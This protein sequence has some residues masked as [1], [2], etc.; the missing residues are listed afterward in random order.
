[1]IGYVTLGTNDIERGR[2]FYDGLLALLGAKRV[3]EFPEEMGGFTLWG[4]S[5]DQLGIALTRPYDGEPAHRGNGHM[6]ALTMA[7]RAQVDALYAKAME[8][9]S[10]CEGPPG[11]RGGEGP[12]AFYAAY[13]RDPDGNKLCVFRMGPA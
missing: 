11:F 3:M 8:L 6:A 5:M 2:A 12:H 1:M 4:V 9:G 7:D 13:F 10:S